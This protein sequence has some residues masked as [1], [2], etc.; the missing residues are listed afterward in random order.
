MHAY[1]SEDG[2]SVFFRDVSERKRFEQERFTMTK[3]E[4]LGTLAGG[5]AHDLNNILTVISGNISLAQIEA[6]A[7]C[8]NLVSFLSKANQAATHA[9]HLSSQLLTFSKGGAPRKQIV[10]LSELLAHSAEFSLYGSNLR[11]DVEIPIEL[12]KVE[13]DSSQIEQAINALLINAREAMPNGGSVKLS[14]R[15]VVLTEE[16]MPLLPAGN[17]VKVLVSDRGSGVPEFLAEKIF[18]PY[19]TTKPSGTGLGLS[20]SY[21]VIKKHGGILQLESSSSEGSG[22]AFYLPASEGELASVEIPLAPIDRHVDQNRILL[23]DDEAA[24]RELTSQLLT[25]LGYEVVAVPDGMDAVRVYDR[26][27][28]RGEYFQ[29]V[30]LDATIRGGMGGLATIERLRMLDPNVNAI[31]CSG[32]SDEAALSEFLTYGFRGALAKPFTRRQL[33]EA[34]QKTLAA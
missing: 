17:Y 29:A 21:S 1:A 27:L 7:E 22:F 13:I 18:D 9:A 31:I 26:A 23:M 25:T 28:R 2:I 10:A 12:W 34:L 19:V 33:S 6:P 3:L 16:E 4:S 5:I 8:V 14:A 20:I 15:N 24:I 30:I 32:Y 11:A